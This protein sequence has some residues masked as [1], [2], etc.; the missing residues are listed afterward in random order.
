MLGHVL[1]PKDIEMTNESI[2]SKQKTGIFY[3]ILSLL[4][5]CDL[6]IKRGHM[7]RSRVAI[8]LLQPLYFCCLKQE[9]DTILQELDK[10]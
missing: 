8:I 2:L 10:A 9:L 4:E 6:L 3:V 1:G 7:Y 5:V